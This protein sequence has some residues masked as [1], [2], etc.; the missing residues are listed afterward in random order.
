MEKVEKILNGYKDYVLEHGKAP[1][2]VYSFTKKL[3]LKEDDFFEHFSSFAAVDQAV[4]ESFFK[5]TVASLEKQ[6][7]YLAYSVREKLLAFYYTWIEVLRSNRSYALYSYQQLKK[8]IF[9]NL[10][11]LQG[12]KGAFYQYATELMLEG[13][14]T[15]EVVT[16]PIISDKYV[17]AMWLQCLYLLDF[18][19]ND[20][21]KG[22]ERTDTAIEKVVNT[23]FDFMGKSVVDSFLDLAKFM[24]QS[25]KP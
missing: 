20:T 13:R 6:E 7:V 16:R 15:S 19:I 24:Y 11:P 17:D 5:E 4:W 3:K 12:L 18:W 8:P 10:G 21:S 1:A 9:R 14:E 22:F 2:T 23:G 25:S